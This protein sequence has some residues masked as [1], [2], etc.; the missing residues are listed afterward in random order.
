MAVTLPAV[1]IILDYYPLGRLDFQSNIISKRKVL[2][3]K[4]PFFGLSFAS[5]VVTIIAQQKGG[6]VTYFEDIS[7]GER[8]LIAV[9]ALAFYLYKILWPAKLAPLYPYPAKVS[10]FMLEYLLALM[11]VFIIT[12]FSIYILRKRKIWLTVWTFY[13]V[14]LLPVLGFIQVGRQSVA[15]RYTYLAS[16]APFL[17]L[18][19][20]VAKLAGK[21]SRGETKLNLVKLFTLLIVPVSFLAIL[22]N[23]TINQT[24]IWKNSITLWKAEIE[25]FPDTV[26][27]AY[28]NLGNAYFDRGR[29]NEAIEQ[30]KIAKQINP[31]DEDVRFNLGNAYYKK[32]YMVRAIREYEVAKE[33]NPYDP[34]IQYALGL[35]YQSQGLIEKAIQQYKI[36]IVLDP[37]NVDAYNDLGNVYHSLGLTDEAIKQY[38]AAI[39]LKPSLMEAH[40]NLGVTYKSKGLIEKANKHF[41]IARKLNPALF[42]EKKD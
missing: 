7:F 18:G 34:D 33:I 21:V 25:L 17:L 29:I 15:D 24:G 32:G 9:R 10:L 30:Y 23:L 31:F 12:A 20:G 19:L 16:V 41:N 27:N 5:S 35:S 4:V 8:I 6:A 1:L 3:E 42:N 22:S 26:F 38:K 36:T 11:I 28:G 39:S 13:V 37:Y 2:M 14:T 40:Y